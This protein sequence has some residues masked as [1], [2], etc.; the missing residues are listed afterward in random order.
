[1]TMSRGGLVD[2]EV[3]FPQ[4]RMTVQQMHEWSGVSIPEILEITHCQEFP[5]L[6][7][8]EQ[9]WE[10]AVDAAATTLD[11]TGT[12]PGSI[13][14]V[15]YAGA[16]YWDAPAWSPAAKVADELGI[17][18]AHCFEVTNFCNALTVGMRIAVDGLTPGSDERVL[19]VAAER[20]AHAVDRRDPDSKGLFNFGDAASAVLVGGSHH[21]FAYLGSSARTDPQWCDYFIG[22]YHDTGV[23]TRRRGHRKGLSDTYVNNFVTL[24][25]DTLDE[26]GR[27]QDDVRFLL[28]NQ[29]DKNIQDRL[30]TTLDLPPERSVYNHSE[31]GHMGCSDTLIALRRLWDGGALDTG[32]LVLLATSGAGFSWSVTALEYRAG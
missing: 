1:M 21:S 11:R 5:V 24:V 16:G 4:G 10:L 7:P 15:I 29:N 13:S 6:G 18:R 28:I 14:R 31:L 27:K 9:A 30:L 8:D 32:D 19:V 17:T 26:I 23:Y 20:F 12:D 25:G 3:A 2:F 22:D